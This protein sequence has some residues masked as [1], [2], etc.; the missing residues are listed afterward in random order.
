M[1]KASPSEDSPDRIK[2][3]DDDPRIVRWAEITELAV[4]ECGS[5]EQASRW[6]NTPKIALKG[7]TPIE[8]MVTSAGCDAVE[9]LLRQL[10]L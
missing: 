7:K 3:E 8:A 2:I 6:M 1:A 4:R 9:A 5:L 10:N